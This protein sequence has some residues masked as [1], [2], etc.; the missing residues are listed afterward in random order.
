VPTGRPALQPERFDPSIPENST[1]LEI[2][3]QLS[4]LATDIGRTLPELAVA[5]P[6]AHPAVTS[7]IIGPRTLPQLEQLLSGAALALDDQTFDRIDK[8]VAPGSNHYRTAWRPPGL[9]DSTA[10]RRPLIDRSAA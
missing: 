9:D 7:V 1:K 4:A 10:R 3:E 2:V 8:I 5:F 6:I